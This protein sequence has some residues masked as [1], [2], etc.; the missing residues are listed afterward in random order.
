MD[1]LKEVLKARA[2]AQ[3]FSVVERSKPAVGQYHEDVADGIVEEMKDFA[4][5]MINNIQKYPSF[6]CFT[7]ELLST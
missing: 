2:V 7:V 1:A 3:H 6:A 5:L 4:L